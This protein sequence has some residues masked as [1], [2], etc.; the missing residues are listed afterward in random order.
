MFIELTHDYMELSAGMR[1]L[2]DGSK[3]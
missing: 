2:V 1:L 3:S